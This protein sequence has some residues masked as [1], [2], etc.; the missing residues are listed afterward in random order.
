M[1]NVF[2]LTLA[3]IVTFATGPISAQA[4]PS[5][6]Y[7]PALAEATESGKFLV[8][9]FDVSPMIRIDG[10]VTATSDAIGGFS[11]G[12][13]VISGPWQGRH[14]WFETL[15]SPTEKQLSDAVKRAQQQSKAES[16]RGMSLK[17]SPKER[18]WPL[19][20]AGE[21]VDPDLSATGPLPSGFRLP[22]G[23]KRYK[24]AAYTQEIAVTDD[25][26][27]IT[28]VHRL[29]LDNK[30]W[31]QSGGMLGILNFRSDLYRNRL[32]DGDNVRSWKGDIMVANGLKHV[33]FSGKLVDTFQ[34]NRGWITEFPDGA[35][36]LDVLSNT[37]SGRVFEIRQRL[38]VSGKWESG[39]VYDDEKE[40]PDG[41]YGITAS[42]SSCHAKAGTGSYAKGLVP[43]AD[44]TLSIGFKV[45]EK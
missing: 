1:R 39:V 18:I 24:R 10:T 31:M 34:P 23:A 4:P 30:D 42:C 29:D 41:Y 36:F 2:L 35:L 27:R 37:K 7:G 15:K 22:D 43:G 28:P 6:A 5:K 33:D 26:D 44:E 11:A 20:S 32:A 25:R 21:I 45:L 38:K 14:V 9:W 40:R 12:E 16:E 17:A 19:P 3:A 8:T 13:V